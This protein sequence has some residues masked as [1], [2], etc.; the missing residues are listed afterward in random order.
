MVVSRCAD[1]CRQPRESRRPRARSALRVR[2]RR[3]LRR[4]RGARAARAASHRHHRALRGGIARRSLDPRARRFHP[5]QRGRHAC[6][7]QGREG[8]VDRSGGPRRRIAFITSR[9]TR[10]TARCGPDDAPFHEST[11]VCAEFPVLREQGGLGSSGARLSRDLR[12]RYDGHQLLEQ[13]RA[14]PVPGE[15]DSA[16]A[17]QYP[18]GQAAAGVRRRA[19]GARLAARGGSLRGDLARARRGAGRARCTTSAATARPPTSRWCARCARWWTSVSRERPEL[20]PA[21]PALARAASGKAAV[22]LISHVRDRPGHDRRYAIDFRKA[23]R[24]L[25]YAPARDFATGLR[26]TLDWY[27]ANPGWW[28]ALMGRGYSEWLEKNY[29]R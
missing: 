5:H 24:E 6:A 25:G 17:H 8:A 11:P 21:Y 19:A 3:Y 1:L 26:A 2:A 16:H 9:P 7:A 28:Q 20:R 29:Q 27:I 23:A 13:L 15:A 4:R 14:L 12:P 10:C 22:D 18:A